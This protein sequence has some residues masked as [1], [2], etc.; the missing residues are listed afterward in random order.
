MGQDQVAANAVHFAPQ[1]PYGLDVAREAGNVVL[2][3]E[4]D[5]VAERGVDLKSPDQH[6]VLMLARELLEVV[7]RPAFVFGDHYAGEANA[8]RFGDHFVGGKG[9]V[10]AAPVGVNV[11]IEYGCQA[12]GCLLSVWVVAPNCNTPGAR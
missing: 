11:E 6:Q 10:G 5:Y 1:V 9:A 2:E 7:A 8:G 12:G 4:S 3:S